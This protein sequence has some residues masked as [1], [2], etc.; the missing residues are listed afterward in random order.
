MA[1]RAY[2]ERQAV[3]APLAAQ[4]D[5]GDDG[6]YLGFRDLI[7]VRVAAAFIARGVSP[8]KVR[9]AIVLAKEMV[10]LERPLSTS[11]FRT[12]GRSVFLETMSSEGKPQLIDLFRKQHVFKE[13]VEQSLRGID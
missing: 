5:L 4:I 6:V 13:I 1:S 8:M 10:Q 3:R 9:Q 11:W 2:Q 12:D 7:E